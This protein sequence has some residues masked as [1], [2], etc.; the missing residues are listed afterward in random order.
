M[1]IAIAPKLKEIPAENLASR[2]AHI[3]VADLLIRLV[4][5]GCPHLSFRTNGYG[6]TCASHIESAIPR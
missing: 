1:P 3:R 2:I 6:Q 5:S 4:L